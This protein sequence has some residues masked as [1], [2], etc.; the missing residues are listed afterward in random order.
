MIHCFHTLKKAI[1]IAGSMTLLMSCSFPGASETGED[2]IADIPL[3]TDIVLTD[4]PSEKPVTAQKEQEQIS[5]AQ[6]DD[7]TL[8]AKEKAE[9]VTVLKKKIEFLI[10]NNQFQEAL[11]SY[12]RILKLE[13][14]NDL[15]RKAAHAAFQAKDFET[16]IRYYKRQIS[17]LSL[18]EKELLLRSMRSIKDP[19]FL[20]M[21]ENLKL[22]DYLS[23][24]YKLS[25]TCEYEY[26]S[27]EPAIKKY[28]YQY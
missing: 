3:P 15:E 20:D 23:E 2:T 19:D 28:S 24:A 21:L 13:P 7:N 10:A 22:P 16:A 18:G 26:I 1:L 4:M 17:S 8:S 12:E 6:R 11:T 9:R 25:W 14:S 27:C 5:R